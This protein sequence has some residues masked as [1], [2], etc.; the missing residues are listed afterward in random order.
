MHKAFCVYITH[1]TSVT[2]GLSI[3][4]ISTCDLSIY[5]NVLVHNS[6]PEFSIRGYIAFDASFSTSNAMVL[7]TLAKEYTGDCTIRAFKFVISH[8]VLVKAVVVPRVKLI[9]K[10][11]SI[12]G[13]RLLAKNPFPCLTLDNYGLFG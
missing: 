12:H 13:K 5:L 8:E 7:P 2:S 6:T 10:T 3:S 11:M 4:K 1:S 9:L